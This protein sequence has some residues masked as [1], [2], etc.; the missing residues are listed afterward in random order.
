MGRGPK[1]PYILAAMLKKALLAITSALAGCVIGAPRTTY[2]VDDPF[3]FLAHAASQGVIPVMVVGEPYPGRRDKVED[4]V[5]QAF[6]RTFASLGHPFRATPPRA[7][8]GTKIVVVFNAARPPLAR[9]VCADPTQFGA[10]AAQSRT[11]AAAIY[12]GDGP[13]SEYSMSFPTPQSPE[14]PKFAEMMGQ[15]AYYAIPRERNP[16]R[17]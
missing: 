5:V 10:G 1:G 4:V 9:T 15:L 13:Y 8:E 14:D 11:W 6:T 17:Q 16:D 7:G 12:C 2:H 3:S